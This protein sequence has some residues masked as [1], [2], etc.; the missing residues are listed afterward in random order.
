MMLAHSSEDIQSYLQ[1]KAELG[2]EEKR[3]IYLE[4]GGSEVWSQW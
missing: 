1:Q 2:A 4:G 3:K